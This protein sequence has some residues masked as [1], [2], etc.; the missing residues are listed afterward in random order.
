MTALTSGFR[1]GLVTLIA[2]LLMVGYVGPAIGVA[3]NTTAPDPATWPSSSLSDPALQ[4]WPNAMRIWGPDRYQT[5][6]AAALTLRGSG[7]YPYESPDPGFQKADAF[8]SRPAWVGAGRCPRSIIVVAGDSPADALAATSLSDSTGY[9]SEPYLRRVAAADPLFDPIGG[10]KRVDTDFAPVILTESAR[11]GARE[12]SPTALIAAKDFRSGGCV[13][14][15]DAIIVGGWSAVPV[16]AEQQLLGSGYDSIFRV[17]GQNRFA[18]ATAVATA[19]GTH[20]APEGIEKCF[21]QDPSDALVKTAF[22]AN[23]V[24]EW[25]TAAA[26]CELLEKTVVLADGISGV[27]ALAAGWWTS[28]WQVPVLLHDGSGS[29]PFDTALALQIMDVENVIVLG[30]TARISPAVFSEVQSLVAGSVRRIAGG[31]RYETSVAMARYLGG[32]WGE[33]APAASGSTV[34]VVGSSGQDGPASGWPDALTAGAWCAANSWA[35][36]G[37]GAPKRLISPANG[38]SPRWTDRWRTPARA[39][40]PIVLVNPASQTLPTAVRG[41]LGESFDSGAPWCSSRSAPPGCNEPGFAVV[42]GGTASVPSKL[43][44]EISILVGGGPDYTAGNP[45]LVQDRVFVTSLHLSALFHQGGT[46]TTKLCALRGAFSDTRWVLVGPN[47]DL[48]SGDLRYVD[49]AEN[50]WYRRDFDGQTRS[51]GL[52]SPGCLELDPSWQ[53]SLAISAVGLDGRR[54]PLVLADI[55]ASA[56]YEL[57]SPVQVSNPQFGGGLASH[58]NAGSGETLLTFALPVGNGVTARFGDRS[59]PITSSSITLTIF[60]G[61]ASSSF[62]GSWNL[63]STHGTAVGQMTGEAV[64]TS[65]SWEFRGRSTVT[66]GSW[67]L[68]DGSGGFFGLLN[69]NSG[70][71]TD[72]V[73]Q[74]EVDGFAATSE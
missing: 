64:M 74:W 9:S 58:V 71:V 35:A 25:R 63:T 23:S 33:A 27:D 39:T 52:S 37:T 28:Y 70:S 16:E 73:L 19:L 2:L 72:D 1:K 57:D 67:P 13:T 3:E 49:L 5:S 31:N 12:L 41:F 45:V 51:L 32:W 17:F 6:L 30:G 40:S 55:S 66:G 29:L 4:T 10:Y 44:D 48:S 38:P 50:S 26:S 18:T 61:G 59:A 43:I 60:R 62:E 15:R 22:Y 68:L 14:A 42:F 65:T 47:S 56:G 21:D 36:S 11:N 34:C 53:D 54:S 8:A 7:G 69:F 20:N 24:V 46:D